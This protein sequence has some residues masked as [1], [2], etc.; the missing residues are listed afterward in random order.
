VDLIFALD[1]VGVLI[2][3][4]LLALAALAVRRRF[5]TRRGGTFDLSLRLRPE[6]HGKG[7]ALGIGRY[8]GDSLEW[9]RVFSY[10][11]RPRRVMGRR[12]LEI[13]DRR[14]PEGPEVFSLLSGAVVV[15]ARDGG[16]PVEFA[17]SPDALTGFLSWLESAPPGRPV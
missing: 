4:L 1:T 10:A 17:M 16:D 6:S 9:Y 8:A 3:V 12:E 15:R 2:V 11:T 14:R 7:W 13:L 5:I